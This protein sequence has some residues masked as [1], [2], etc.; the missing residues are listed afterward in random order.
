MK[1][2]KPALTVN[3]GGMF[4]SKSTTLIAQGKRHLLAGHKVVFIKPDMDTRYSDEDIITH[5]GQ[6]VEAINISTDEQSHIQELILHEADVYLFDEVQFY[7]M[8]IVEDIKYLLDNEKIVYVSGLDMDYTGEPFQVTAY[9]MG[10]ADN[11]N[12]IK[13]VCSDCGDDSYVTAKTSGSS[14]RVEL[15]SS[16]I[17]KP[18]CRNCYTKY[19]EDVK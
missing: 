17:Y 19:K 6:K 7:S 3:V 11:V 1:Q 14:S 12:K 5:D 16:D 13:A 9:L 18:V 2:K 10:I 15:G 4:A 8:T